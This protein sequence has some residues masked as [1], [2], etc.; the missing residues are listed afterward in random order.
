MRT[1]AK[2]KKILV[3]SSNGNYPNAVTLANK[4]S[5]DKGNS[6]SLAIS[7]SQAQFWVS[8]KEVGYFGETKIV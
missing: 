5:E 7:E 2:R 6:V 4:L 3:I 1:I 8:H